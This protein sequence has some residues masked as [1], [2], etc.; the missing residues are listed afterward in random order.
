VRNIVTD[1]YRQQGWHPQSGAPLMGTLQALEID[2]YAGFAQ[3]AVDSSRGIAVLPPVVT[4][5]AAP[6][7]MHE[8]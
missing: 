7:E 5:Q 1:Y 8:E 4:L 6:E 2:D 3:R